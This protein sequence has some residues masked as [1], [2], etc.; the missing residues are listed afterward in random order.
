[1]DSFNKNKVLSEV[2][3]LVEIRNIYLQTAIGNISFNSNKEM[4]LPYLN[5][6]IVELLKSIYGEEQ[7]KQNNKD[8]L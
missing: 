2:R 1:M 8:I 3:K 6:K 5:N 4:V 7:D